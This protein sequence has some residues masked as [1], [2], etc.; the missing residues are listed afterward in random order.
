MRFLLVTLFLVLPCTT[1]AKEKKRTPSSGPGVAC[2]TVRSLEVSK[3]QYI[4][5]DEFIIQYSTPTGLSLGLNIINAALVSN[6]TN[7]LCISA[8]QESLDAKK[9]RSEWP[10]L[11]I[12]PRRISVNER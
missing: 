3:G 11:T 5:N 7:D 12:K 2:L 10:S 1:F 8:D 9:I 6:N 4:L